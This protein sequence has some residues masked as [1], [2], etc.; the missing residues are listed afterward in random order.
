[1][2]CTSR[3]NDVV[4]SRVFRKRPVAPP[5]VF[6]GQKNCGFNMPGSPLQYCLRAHHAFGLFW[7]RYRRGR[8]VRGNPHLAWARL[9]SHLDS[10]FMFVTHLCVVA[11]HY[12]TTCPPTSA[13]SSH[14][15][16]RVRGGID[17][18]AL[19]LPK[20]TKQGVSRSCGGG[21]YAV[22]T[23]ITCPACACMHC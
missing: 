20:V 5:T 18:D 10:R 19:V 15:A 23:R 21:A 17:S 13:V 2:R 9:G 22:I 12:G 6:V 14:F 11:S 4:T 1:M 16:V 3:C 8:L 7:V